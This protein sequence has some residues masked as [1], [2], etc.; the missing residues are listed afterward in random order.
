M[1]SVVS[2]CQSVSQQVISKKRYKCT[3]SA[4]IVRPLYLPLMVAISG[5]KLRRCRFFFRRCRFSD[6]KPSRYPAHSRDVLLALLHETTL[7]AFFV[8]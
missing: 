6:F 2:V 4:G 3:N 1:F 8:S 7:T 5:K